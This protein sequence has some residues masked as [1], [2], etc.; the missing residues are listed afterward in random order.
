M[1]PVA[2]LEEII[3]ASGAAPQIEA[4]LPIGV[5]PRQLKVRARLLR[6]PRRHQRGQPVQRVDRR[7]D[8]LYRR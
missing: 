4:V 6:Q 7:G 1:I 2:V 8:D 5:R 3:D